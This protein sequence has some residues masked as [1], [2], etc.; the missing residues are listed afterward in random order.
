MNKYMALSEFEEMLNKKKTAVEEERKPIQELRRPE[1]SRLR[2][3]PP[4]VASCCILLA[5]VTGAAFLR[6][7]GKIG[8]VLSVAEAAMKDIGILKARMATDDTKE[9]FAAIKAQVNDLQAARMQ[10]EDEVE[11]MKAIVET[12]K[13][14]ANRARGTGKQMAGGGRKTVARTGE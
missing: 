1:L 3:Y 4:V 5:L 9:H 12:V 14:S 6:V 13:N 2:R 10:L 8:G 7:E 11:Q